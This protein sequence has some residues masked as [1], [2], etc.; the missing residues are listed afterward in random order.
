MKYNVYDKYINNA[1]RSAINAK[2]IT[3]EL[4]NKCLTSW[5]DIMKQDADYLYLKYIYDYTFVDKIIN[6]TKT[7]E[8]TYCLEMPE[9]H[10]FIQNGIN[11]W[12]CQGSQYKKVIVAMD[13]SAYL[14]LNAEQLYTALTRAKSHCI[15]VI[16]LSALR[17]AINNRE[18][19]KK[20]TYLSKK[21]IKI[22]S[23]INCV[24]CVN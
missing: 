17:K 15:L 1:L 7:I 2:K 22:K 23:S 9:T 4:L 6:I 8:Q 10:K 13:N 11:A 3:Y 14:L 21:L 12:N 5:N 20:Q 16:Q 19:K 24:N 18:V